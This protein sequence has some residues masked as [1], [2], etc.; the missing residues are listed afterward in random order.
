MLISLHGRDHVASILLLHCSFFQSKQFS[1]LNNMDGKE[2][3]RKRENLEDVSETGI[4][5]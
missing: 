5:L 1:A 3:L 2:V 4:D